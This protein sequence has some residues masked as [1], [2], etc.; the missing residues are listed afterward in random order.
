[1]DDEARKVIC[2]ELGI[3]DIYPNITFDRFLE[4]TNHIRE[5][6]IESTQIRDLHELPPQK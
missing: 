2:E 5:N 1:M 6:R 4:W 3:V